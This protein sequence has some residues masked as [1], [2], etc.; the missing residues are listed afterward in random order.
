MAICA[1]A[2]ELPS[3]LLHARKALRR[4]RIVKKNALFPSPCAELRGNSF[5]PVAPYARGR[6]NKYA[7]RVTQALYQRRTA[8]ESIGGAVDIVGSSRTAYANGWHV[9]KEFS[10]ANAMREAKPPAMNTMAC[11]PA[12]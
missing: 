1:R 7:C 2:N 6:D 5:P 12:R 8:S 9:R 10:T 3:D 11:S 4:F